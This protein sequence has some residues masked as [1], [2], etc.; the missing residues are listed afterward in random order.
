[1][2]LCFGHMTITVARVK[3]K[4]EKQDGIKDTSNSGEPIIIFVIL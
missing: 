1:M 2:M 4:S 3:N